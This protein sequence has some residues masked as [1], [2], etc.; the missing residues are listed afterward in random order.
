MVK[1]VLSKNGKGKVLVIDGGA[2]MRRALIGDLIAADLAKNQWEGAIVNGCIRD[3]AKI[4]EIAGVG[5]KALGT[6]PRKTE[7]K[8]V[9]EEGLVLEFGGVKWVPGGW[10]AADEDGVVVAE[11]DLRKE[12]S[13]L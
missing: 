9:G 11:F 7:K 12:K 8:G 13:G 10:V 1:K 5:I 4:A 3:S 6:H 2:S